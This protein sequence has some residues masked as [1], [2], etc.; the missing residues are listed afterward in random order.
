MESKAKDER[1][2]YCTYFMGYR[3]RLSIKTDD[4]NGW[5]FSGW[6]WSKGG[7]RGE[8]RSIFLHLAWAFLVFSSAFPFLPPPPFPTPP[9]CYFHVSFW[10]LWLV[11]R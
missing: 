4:G 8:I 10:S 1:R 2:V 11:G 3:T 7:G 5:H 9:L 6:W